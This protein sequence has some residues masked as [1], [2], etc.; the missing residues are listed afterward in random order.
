MDVGWD[1][2]EKAVGKDLVVMVWRGS[3]GYSKILKPKFV[4]HLSISPEGDMR[5]IRG[6]RRMGC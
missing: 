2:K 3:Q 4:I 1:G 5:R 6:E